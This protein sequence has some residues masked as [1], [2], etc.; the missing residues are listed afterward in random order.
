MNRRR[1][2]FFQQKMN[3]NPGK[4]TPLRHVWPGVEERYFLKPK[5]IPRCLEQNLCCCLIFLSSSSLSLFSFPPHFRF[6]FLLPLREFNFAFFILFICLLFRRSSLFIVS[7]KS[8]YKN[9]ICL[10]NI[11]Y[12]FYCSFNVFHISPSSLLMQKFLYLCYDYIQKRQFHIILCY[13]LFPVII[14]IINIFIAFKKKLILFWWIHLCCSGKKYGTFRCR[15]V[16]NS[17]I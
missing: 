9:S 7:C 8:L 17:Y 11:P 2:V 6:G 1:L 10:N 12:S 15:H 3:T 5:C 13:F 4:L 16:D 14:W